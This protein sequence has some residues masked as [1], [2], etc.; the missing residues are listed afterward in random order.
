[1][2]EHKLKIDVSWSGKNFCRAWSDEEV[3][4][5]VVT[6][7][8]LDKLKADFANLLNF[9]WGMCR[10]WWRTSTISCRWWLWPWI[11]SRHCSTAQECRVIYHNGSAQQGVRHKPKATFALCQWTKAAS[12]GSTE[13]NHWRSSPYRLKDTGCVL[14]LIW[15]QNHTLSGRGIFFPTFFGVSETLIYT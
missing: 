14:V 5:I 8:T 7:K 2:A 15:Q 3:G 10:R 1:M 13:S 6:A 11:C 12:W 4:S 9:N